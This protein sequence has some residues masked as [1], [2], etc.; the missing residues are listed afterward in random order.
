MLDK[1]SFLGG[2]KTLCNSC[3]DQEHPP[4]SM[5]IWAHNQE[6]TSPERTR[7]HHKKLAT[8]NP[9]KQENQFR[10][11]Q[12]AKTTCSET[13][14]LETGGNFYGMGSEEFGEGKKLLMIQCTTPYLMGVNR[15]GSLVFIDV[16]ANETRDEFVVCRFVWVASKPVGRCLRVQLASDRKHASEETTTFLRQRHET[17][18]NGQVTHLA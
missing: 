7:V 3:P 1:T 2:K 11:W 17:F 6:E 12:K 9:Q 13:Q 8:G 10:V 18:S 15:T 16:T 4:R 14:P 5:H